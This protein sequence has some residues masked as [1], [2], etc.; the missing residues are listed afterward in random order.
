MLGCAKAYLSVK[1]AHNLSPIHKL[2]GFGRNRLKQCHFD[3]G[4]ILECRN[5]KAAAQRCFMG[6]VC[7]RLKKL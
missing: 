3:G 5:V 2:V 6:R 1:Q 7:A 4:W